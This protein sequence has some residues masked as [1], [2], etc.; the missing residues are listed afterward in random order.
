MHVTLY[1]PFI[2]LQ[3]IYHE[4][5]DLPCLCLVIVWI[6]DVLFKGKFT[7]SYITMGCSRFIFSPFLLCNPLSAIF[8]CRSPII[9]C[10]KS[11]ITV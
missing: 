5:K 8:F 11:I 1:A 4:D 10:T 3:L 6:E 7:A 2:K 9:R